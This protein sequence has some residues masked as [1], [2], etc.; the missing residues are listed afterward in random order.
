MEGDDDDDD[1]D[2]EDEDDDEVRQASAF[3][4]SEGNTH[5]IVVDEDEDDFIV[6]GDACCAA[7]VTQKFDGARYLN[8]RDEKSEFAASSSNGRLTGALEFRKHDYRFSL[9][10]HSAYAQGVSLQSLA[11]VYTRTT[12]LLGAPLSTLTITIDSDG[13]L[14]GSHSNGCVLNGSASVPEPTRNIVR[15]SVRVDSCGTQLGSSRRWNGEYTGLGALLRNSP[16]P[17]NAGAREDTLLLSLVGP[18]WLGLMS[19]GK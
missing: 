10:M 18:T 3:V 9:D 6:Y 17:G 14:T 12:Y 5:L 1:D 4:D 11:G 7:S 19:V 15:F 2:D 16:I 13:A 8:S